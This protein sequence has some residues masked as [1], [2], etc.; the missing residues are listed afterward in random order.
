MSIQLEAFSKFWTLEEGLLKKETT[1]ERPSYQLY[2][3]GSLHVYPPSF[4]SGGLI[5]FE[6]LPKRFPGQGRVNAIF[7]PWGPEPKLSLG[8]VG[9]NMWDN[10]CLSQSAE[11]KVLLQSVRTAAILSTVWW[12]LQPCLYP[13]I[14][15][16]AVFARDMPYPAFLK[17][18][19]SK[20]NGSDS[21]KSCA[22]EPNFSPGS[23]SA[24]ELRKHGQCAQARELKF[25]TWLP[26]FGCWLLVKIPKKRCAAVKMLRVWVKTRESYQ[27]PSMF[28][29]GMGPGK[30]RGAMF[31]RSSAERIFVMERYGFSIGYPG[32]GTS[33]LPCGRVHW[34]GKTFRIVS[35]PETID[36]TGGLGEIEVGTSQLFLRL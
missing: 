33:T 10:M 31:V 2:P 5:R 13:C 34:R 16:D 35:C 4:G 11:P 28:V 6:T 23:A 30:L 12:V 20:M 7:H 27:G 17:Q 9:D 19:G 36:Q 24:T 25:V 8:Q 1:T 3:D 14:A 18:S 21:E 15:S 22:F 32:S 26:R 29:S